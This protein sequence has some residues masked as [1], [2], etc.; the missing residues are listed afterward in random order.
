[1][2]CVTWIFS[3][4]W[5]VG[6]WSIVAEALDGQ[7]LVSSYSRVTKPFELYCK[8][9]CL[10]LAS[11]NGSH[12]LSHGGERGGAHYEMPFI[13]ADML[14][15]AAPDTD[16]FRAMTHPGN[17]MTANGSAPITELSLQPTIS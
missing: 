16:C 12:G 14:C 9:S 1:M 11:V 17:T 6:Q 13:A 8:A 5:R 2:S 7:K 15:S 10:G 4:T 3:F